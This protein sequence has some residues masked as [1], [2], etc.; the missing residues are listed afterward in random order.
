MLGQSSSPFRTSTWWKVV[1]F[2]IACH[3]GMIYFGIE[4]QPVSKATLSKAETSLVVQTIRLDPPTLHPTSPISLVI[5]ESSPAPIEKIEKEEKPLKEELPVIPKQEE[6]IPKQE[7]QPIK[8]KEA[9]PL[10]QVTPKENKEIKPKEEK[11]IPPPV[12][13]EKKVIPLPPPKPVVL[14]PAKPKPETV[15]TQ[16]ISEAE[17]KRQKEVEE[18]KKKKAEAMERERKRQAELER[19][20]LEKRREEEKK[21]QE[22]VAKAQELAKQK[23][24]K[25]SENL[26]KMKETRDKSE[27]VVFSA[28]PV[29]ALLPKHVETLQVESLLSVQTF[30]KENWGSKEK[31]YS[32]KVATCLKTALRLPDYGA[33]QIQLTLDRMGKVVKIVILK[34]QSEKNKQ[35]VQNKISTLVFPPFGQHFQGLTESTFEI[36]LQNDA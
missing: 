2:V 8:Q 9:D 21:K 7:E 16:T 34:S 28:Q 35:Y 31:T 22:E 14:P 13:E 27:P 23:M 4:W 10:P 17:K 25:V 24:A 26:A 19:V 11:K 20:E 32:D 18:E 29:D 5:E 33:V 15:K 12:K 36:T 30:Q 3:V 6:R 1:I